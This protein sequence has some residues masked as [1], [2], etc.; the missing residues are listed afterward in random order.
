ML[1]F[2]KIAN[3]NLLSGYASYIM[4]PEPISTEYYKTLPIS[5][6]VYICIPLLVLDNGSTKTLPPQRIHT[7]Q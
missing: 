7:E 3:R 2:F 6:C 5:L 4:A 1:V